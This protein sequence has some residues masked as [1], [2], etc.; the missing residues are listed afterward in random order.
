[1][2]LITLFSLLESTPR[3]GHWDCPQAAVL[4]RNVYRF[5]YFLI[6]SDLQLGRRFRTPVGDTL[7]EQIQGKK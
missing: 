2:T 5:S 1:L 6:V 3:I 7:T 4:R